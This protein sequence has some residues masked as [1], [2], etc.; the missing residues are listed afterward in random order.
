MDVAVALLADG[1]TALLLVRN[2]ELHAGDRVLVEAAA[3]GLGSLLVQLAHNAGATVVAAAGGKRKLAIAREV[4]ADFVVDY[5]APDW[6]E[7]V[8]AAVGAIDVVFDGVGGTIGAAA[9]ELIA[10]GGRM[11]TYGMASGTF[12]SIADADATARRHDAPRRTDHARALARAHEGRARRSRGRTPAPGHRSA[13]PARPGRRGPRR[14][15]GARHGRQDPARSLR[16]ACRARASAARLRAVPTSD[17]V[18]C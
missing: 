17:A 1:R 9:F 3:G 12:T 18:S 11:S 8:R 13:L 7:Q 16:C 6:P 4:G 14:D 10:T 2:A 5:D 15:R